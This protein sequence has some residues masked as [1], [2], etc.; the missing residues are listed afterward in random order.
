MG[1]IHEQLRDQINDLTKRVQNLERR[2]H[3]VSTT[4]DER[5]AAAELY[6]ENER[7]RARQREQVFGVVDDANGR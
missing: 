2:H 4:E 5:A 1:A 7:F 3:I 6:R